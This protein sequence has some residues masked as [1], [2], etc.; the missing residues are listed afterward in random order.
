M[1]IRTSAKPCASTE[2]LVREMAA[3]IAWP[4]VMPLSNRTSKCEALP[5]DLVEWTGGR[6]L[7]ATGSRFDP[8]IYND[9]T[10]EIAQA[11]DALLFPGLRL[12]VVVAS[13]FGSATGVPQGQRTSKAGSLVGQLRGCSSGDYKKVIHGG[14]PG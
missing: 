3:R 10:H 1:L 12:E 6:V 11:N 14:V 7:T 2:P 9:R 5:A 8:V 13:F 4:I